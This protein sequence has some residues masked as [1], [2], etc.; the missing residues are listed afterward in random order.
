MKNINQIRQ[1]IVNLVNGQIKDNK[2]YDTDNKLSFWLQTLDSNGFVKDD[3]FIGTMT[4]ITTDR[5][6]YC[7]KECGCNDVNQ[8]MFRLSY[9]LL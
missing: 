5:L 1:E 3:I 6:I 7:A 2:K 8:K 4:D 9:N